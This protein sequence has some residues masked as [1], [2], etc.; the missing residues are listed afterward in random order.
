MGYGPDLAIWSIDG[1]WS[2]LQMM[3]F[4]T[5]SRCWPMARRS[6]PNKRS[7]VLGIVKD[8]PPAAVAQGGPSLTAPARGALHASQVGTKEWPSRSN[9]GIGL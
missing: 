1:K 8:E 9:K 3:V 5:R 6:R 7:A 4:N 2:Y